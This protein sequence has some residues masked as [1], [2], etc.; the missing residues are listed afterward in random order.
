MHGKAFNNFLAVI[1]H[2]HISHFYEQSSNKHPVK[3]RSEVEELVVFCC[4]LGV[5]GIFL[6]VELV[7]LGL[8]DYSP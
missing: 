4:L 5:M 1:F 6:G 7:F 3:R 8:K 2:W